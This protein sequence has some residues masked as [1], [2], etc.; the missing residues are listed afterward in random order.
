MSKWTDWFRLILRSPT[1]TDIMIELETSTE[2][3]VLTA[4]DILTGI[5]AKYFRHTA[6]SSL[7]IKLRK[8]EELKSIKSGVIAAPGRPRRIGYWLNRDSWKLESTVL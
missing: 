6:L 8:L 3:R 5:D 7:I 2:E 4:S 1:Y